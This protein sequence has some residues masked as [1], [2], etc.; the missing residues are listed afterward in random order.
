[1][2]KATIARFTPAASLNSQI[3]TSTPMITCVVFVGVHHDSQCMKR[4]ASPNS[5][6]SATVIRLHSRWR[7]RQSMIG[8]AKKAPHNIASQLKG[9][10]DNRS[11]KK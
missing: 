9:M 4:E 2:A 3:T 7:T 1:M 8:N 5:G 11:P 10:P 6:A